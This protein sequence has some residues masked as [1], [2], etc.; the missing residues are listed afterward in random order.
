MDCSGSNERIGREL[1]SN[2]GGFGGQTSKHPWNITG[3]YQDSVTQEWA[4]QFAGGAMRA[5]QRERV[6]NSWFHA[7]GLG[8]QSILLDA[9]SAAAA[10]D[11]IVVSVYAAH[12]LPH[13]LR[14]WFQAWLSR[15][16]PRAGALAAL[17]GSEEALDAKVHTLDYLQSVARM[18]H[19]D[20]IPREHRCS[21]ASNRPPG[22]GNAGPVTTTGKSLPH[23]Y[24]ERYDAYSIGL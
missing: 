13:P 19:L 3:V 21:P 20:F 1:L 16:L 24:G 23:I 8:D 5:A 4:L 17:I 12:E 11:V 18:A 7:Q 14:I 15:R 10:A 9:A 6:Q 22:E 2:T